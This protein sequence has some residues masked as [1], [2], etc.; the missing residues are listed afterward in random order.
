MQDIVYIM[1]IF[2]LA[3]LLEVGIVDADTSPQFSVLNFGAVGNGV[4]DDTQVLLKK[5][6]IFHTVNFKINSS[7][8]EFCLLFKYFLGLL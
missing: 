6:V 3:P 1:L 2:G 4:V 7:N 8:C 5:Y